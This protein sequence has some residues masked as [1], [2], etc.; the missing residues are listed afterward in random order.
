MVDEFGGNYLDANYDEGKYW[1][2]KDTF[3]RFL[4]DGHTKELR[5][6]HHTLANV[7]IAEYPNADWEQRAIHLFVPL[8]VAE[9]GSHW[10]EGDLKEGN[11]KPVWNELAV[12]YSPLAVSMNLWDQNFTPSQEI[13]LPIQWFNDTEKDQTLVAQLTIKEGDF[14][15]LSKNCAAL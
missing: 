9:D 1:T 4:G 3:R 5:I 10:F 6:E 2:I 11:P 12:V 7:K 15:V 8:A 13:D 14:V